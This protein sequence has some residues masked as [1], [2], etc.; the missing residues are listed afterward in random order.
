MT[1]EPSV[2]ELRALSKHAAERVALYRRK[3]YVGTGDL[4]R[5]AE[6][7]RVAEGAAARLRRALSA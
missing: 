4:Q 5:L 7:E 1:G 2:T 3:V 6:L